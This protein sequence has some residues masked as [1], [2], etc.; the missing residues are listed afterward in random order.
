[1]REFDALSGSLRVAAVPDVFPD[2]SLVVCLRLVSGGFSVV[3]EHFSRCVRLW[4]LGKPV[5]ELAAF[6][7]YGTFDE[8]SVVTGPLVGSFLFGVIDLRL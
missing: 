8:A 7:V 4:F 3:D 2:G 6:F 1:M 5:E